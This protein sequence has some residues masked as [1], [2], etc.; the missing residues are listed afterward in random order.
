VVPPQRWR[1]RCDERRLLLSSSFTQL[2]RNPHG[3]FLEVSPRC[4]TKLSKNVS[5]SFLPFS[6]ILTCNFLGE[7]Y[8]FNK[9]VKSSSCLCLSF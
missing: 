2:K 1:G 6:L 8:Y 7:N 9:F 5:Q 4:T 3:A